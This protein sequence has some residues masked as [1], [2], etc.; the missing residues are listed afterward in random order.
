MVHSL[1]EMGW[2]E[3]SNIEKVYNSNFENAVRFISRENAGL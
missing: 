1:F 2:P 3:K